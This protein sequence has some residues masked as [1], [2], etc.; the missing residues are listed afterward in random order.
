MQVLD[1]AAG[2]LRKPLAATI[3]YFE[4][5]AQAMLAQVQSAIAAH[6][7]PRHFVS[8]QGSQF[9]ADQ[10]KAALKALGIRQRFGA[11]GEHGSIALIERFWKTLKH[12][13]RLRSWK[14]WN[15]PDFQKR[16]VPALV[17]YSY[18]RPHSALGARTPAEVFFG[19]TLERPI[20]N[21]APR[22]RPDDPQIDC[23]FEIAFL[24]PDSKTL[25]ILVPRA[26]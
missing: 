21:L 16:L 15:L 17:R 20:L 2:V 25:P 18:C 24:D 14:P 26:A 10:F 9:A 12:D 19:I 6:G 11:L 23:P 1:L 8:D 5:S 3:S 4:P 7:E 22:G 13:L